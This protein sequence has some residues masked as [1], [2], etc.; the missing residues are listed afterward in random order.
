VQF[1]KPVTARYLRLIVN[2]PDQGGQTG[3]QMAVSEL[4]VYGLLTQW[5]EAGGVETRAGSPPRY[6]GA[7]VT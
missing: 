3:G 5:A 1:D 4:G 6:V 7:P 2:R